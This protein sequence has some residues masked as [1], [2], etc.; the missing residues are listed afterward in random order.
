M[1]FMR[2]VKFKKKV[3]EENN[4]IPFLQVD[5]HPHNVNNEDDINKTQPKDDVNAALLRVDVHKNVNADDTLWLNYKKI[6]V[7]IVLMLYS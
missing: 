7:S 5:V 3:N 4:Y 2:Q 6:V 1:L